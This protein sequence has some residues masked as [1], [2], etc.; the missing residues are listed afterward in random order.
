MTNSTPATPRG[1][2]PSAVCAKKPSVVSTA[3]RAVEVRKPQTRNGASGSAMRASGTRGAASRSRVAR[4]SADR[5][6]GSANADHDRVREPDRAR[7]EVRRAQAERRVGEPAD[8]R[9]ERHAESDARAERAHAGAA[10][11]GRGHVGDVG[12]ERRQRGRGHEPAEHARG[13]QLR[14]VLAEA[15]QDEA[16]RVA[17]QTDHQRRLAPARARE[18]PPEGARDERRER[19]RRQQPA[20]VRVRDAELAGQER[21]HREQH[22]EP[23]HEHERG[24]RGESDRARHGRG[25]VT[26]AP[27]HEKARGRVESRA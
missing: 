20:R 24:E 15:E 6:S 23:E 14:E 26:H 16:E 25:R 18:A 21:Q 4:A 1:V 27:R 17:D 22:A 12:E 3:M 9:A 2:A 5:L 19:V 11:L 7:H 8:Q 10:L 13:E